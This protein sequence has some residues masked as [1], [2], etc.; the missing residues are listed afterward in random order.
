MSPLT[1]MARNRSNGGKTD[2]LRWPERRRILSVTPNVLRVVVLVSCACAL[3]ELVLPDILSGFLHLLQSV[4]EALFLPF[5]LLFGLALWLAEG[6]KVGNAVTD[7]GHAADVSGQS[8]RLL[9]YS[10]ALV[11]VAGAFSFLASFSGRERRLVGLTLILHCTACA[12]L[13]WP[14]AL[15]ML[16]AVL[17]EAFALKWVSS[18]RREV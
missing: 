15:L 14:G 10:T 6:Q 8:A 17:A 5:R 4:F 3:A 9:S 2:G 13:Q 11:V 12:L 16:P 1:K 18:S 7:V